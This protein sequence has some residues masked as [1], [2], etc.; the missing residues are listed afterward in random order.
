LFPTL[1]ERK[2]RMPLEDPVPRGDPRRP[3]AAF[4]LKI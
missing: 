4:R 3:W 2:L 1:I